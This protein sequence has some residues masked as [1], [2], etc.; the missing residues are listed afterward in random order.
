MTKKIKAFY[1]SNSPFVLECGKVIPVITIAYH[2]FGELNPAQDNVVW[3]CHALTANSDIADWWSDTLQ[4]GQF[5][6]PENNFVICANILGSP[7]G[8]TSPLS[9]DLSTGEPYYDDFPLITV[10]DIVKAHRLLAE[11]LKITRAKMII[12]SSIGG[13]QAME[14]LIQQPDFAETAVLIATG[15]MAN[16]WAIAL[17]ESQRMALRCDPTYGERRVNAGANG[18]AVARS[19]AMLSYRGPHAYVISQEDTESKLEDFRAASYQRYQGVKLAERFDAY[20][21]YRLTQ[22]IDSHNIGRNRGGVPEALSK[23][24]ARCTI[25]CVDSDLL[26][27]QSDHCVLHENIKNSELHVLESDYGHD[28]FLVESEKL[29]QIIIKHLNNYDK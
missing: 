27:P 13:F 2:T 12:G 24:T 29:N 10:R 16:A 23:I 3:V 21:Y 8:S 9:I 19:I 11:H 28:G 5:L 1:R 14:W 17:N 7:Y 4:E 18:L 20:C 15:T 25:I 6:S 22:A 26:F